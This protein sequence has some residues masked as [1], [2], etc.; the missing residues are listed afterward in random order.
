MIETNQLRP[1]VSYQGFDCADTALSA[2]MPCQVDKQHCI[3]DVH[4]MNTVLK[5]CLIPCRNSNVSSQAFQGTQQHL[6]LE[7]LA[8]KLTC[9]RARH[10]IVMPH[11][12]IR[13]TT[14]S[15]SFNTI[16]CRRHRRRIQRYMHAQCDSRSGGCFGIRHQERNLPVIVTMTGGCPAPIK[17]RADG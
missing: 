12:S 17:G 2:F 15:T 5:T 9:R 3:S 11:N 14:V 1:D 6:N 16:F 10:A 7:R 8:R 4:L 13:S